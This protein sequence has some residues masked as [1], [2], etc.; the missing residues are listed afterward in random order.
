LTQVTCRLAAV[1]SSVMPAWMRTSASMTSTWA[2]TRSRVGVADREPD[3]SRSV[4]IAA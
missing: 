1:N 2:P 3:M 4:V